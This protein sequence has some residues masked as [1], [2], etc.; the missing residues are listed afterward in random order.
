[1]LAT[2]IKNKCMQGVTIYACNKN[3]RWSQITAALA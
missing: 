2:K 1:M 3:K